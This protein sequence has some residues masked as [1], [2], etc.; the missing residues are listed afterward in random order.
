MRTL[1]YFSL[2]DAANARLAQARLG[3][4]AGSLA[5]VAGPWFVKRDIQPVDGL[6]MTDVSQTT[7]REEAAITGMFIGA[8]VQIRRFRRRRHHGCC[9]CCRHAS[10]DDRMVALRIGRR[11][12]RSPCTVAAECASRT[13]PIAVIVSSDSRSKEAL[14]Q[15]INELGGVGV[16]GHN[17]LMPNFIWL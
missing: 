6:P 5:L 8:L 7:Y 15:L 13:E 9:V 12:G 17:D 10:R 14:E 16:D 4:L 3:D 11:Q 1:L 2:R